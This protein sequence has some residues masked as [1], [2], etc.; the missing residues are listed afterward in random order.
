MNRTTAGRGRERGAKGE[1]GAG[2]AGRG[3]AGTVVGCGRTG[4]GGTGFVS[5]QRGSCASPGGSVPKGRRPVL[6]GESKRSQ[7]PTTCFPDLCGWG[8]DGVQTGRR[9]D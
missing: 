5:T 8:A 7:V 1:T 9:S 6:P 4:R 3:R 2:G